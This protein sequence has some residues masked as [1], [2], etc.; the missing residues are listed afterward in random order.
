[1]MYGEQQLTINSNDSKCTMRRFAGPE[2]DEFFILCAPARA[3]AGDVAGQTRSLYRGLHQAL[4][5]AGGGVRHV[6]HET[7]FFR[8]IGRDLAAFRRVRTEVLGELSCRVCRPA[9]TCI[10]QPP[11][12]P[13]ARVEIAALAVIPR[14][15]AQKFGRTVWSAPTCGCA[16]SARFAARVVRLGA[17]EYLYAGNIFGSDGSAFDE[18]F[19][20]LLAAEQ[21]LRAQG[22]SF[23]EVVRTWI[24]LRDIDRDYAEFNRARREFFRRSGISLR[25]ASTGIG[26]APFAGRHNFSMSLYAIKSPAPLEVGVMTTPTLNEAWTYGADFSRGLK[27]VEANK[28]ALY[29]SGT[30]SVDEEGH[31]AHVGDFER[32]VERM[33]INVE[34]LLTAQNAS[35]RDLVSAVTYVKHAGD[36]PRLRDILRHHGVEGFPNAIV[37]AAVCRANLLCEMEAVAA[38]PRQ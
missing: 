29:V 33:I 3:A 35:L 37:N 20:M 9:S 34:A 5:A 24:H 6:V 11:L 27:V 2:A 38:L 16:A 23:G 21:L 14:Q 7:I 19:G 30:A 10:E 18:A 26:G 8:D 32:Q 15:R 28:V 17:Q 25:P 22:L 4:A 12:D 31:T 13:R 1:M 36:A